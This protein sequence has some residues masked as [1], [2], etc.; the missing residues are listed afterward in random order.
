MLHFP[1][2][3]GGGRQLFFSRINEIGA[4]HAPVL[5]AFVSHLP[6]HGPRVEYIGRA[7]DAVERLR[8]HEKWGRAQAIDSCAMCFVHY[9]MGTEE[10]IAADER[11]LIMTQRPQLNEQHNRG[12]SLVQA[13]MQSNHAVRDGGLLG[14]Q[15]ARRGLLDR[16]S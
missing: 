1:M 12:L 13:L 16:G 11:W 15:L 7:G 14:N 3:V 2:S 4:F 10:Q 8:R 5:Y 9:H 6:G